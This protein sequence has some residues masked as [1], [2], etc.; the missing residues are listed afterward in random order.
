MEPGK[1]RLTATERE[2]LARINIA[3]RFLQEEPRDLVRRTAM[4]RRGGWYLGVA[5]GMLE[6]YMREVNQTIPPE[7]VK[8][9][10]RSIAESTIT[11]GVRCQATR[12]RNRGTEYGVIVPIDTLNLLFAACLD[13]C[14][15]CTGDRE[16]Q[17]RC[18]LRK[19]LDV[20]PND[21]EERTDGGCQYRGLL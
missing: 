17:A 14:L 3:K 16:S 21:A 2:A 8:A 12:D 6:R 4:I 7:Q 10:E 15:T 19:A 9:F 20:I 1:R 5:R 13:H 11:V 18:D